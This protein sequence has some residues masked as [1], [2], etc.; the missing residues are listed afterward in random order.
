M[1]ELD[2]RAVPVETGELGNAISLLEA[3]HEFFVD[4]VGHFHLVG[5]ERESGGLFAVDVEEAG[6][7][8]VRPAGPL[9]G[10]RVG[11]NSHRR[12]ARRVPE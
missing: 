12:P 10:R 5:P 1:E 9:G 8:V 2:V 4:V 7:D 3:Q 11:I 6:F